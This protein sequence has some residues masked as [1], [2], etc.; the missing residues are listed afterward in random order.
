M[1]RDFP[2]KLGTD[3]LT[4]L[5]DHDRSSDSYVIHRRS[6]KVD[7]NDLIFFLSG[8][9]RSFLLIELKRCVTLSGMVF[10]LFVC[11]LARK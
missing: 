6:D 3:D 11:E 5:T 9:F 10:R 1:E 8:L 2:T 7:L 4:S